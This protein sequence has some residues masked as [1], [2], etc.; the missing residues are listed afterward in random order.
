MRKS[1][2]DALRLIEKHRPDLAPEFLNLRHFGTPQVARWLD[3]HFPIPGGWG[4]RL[5]WRLALDLRELLE[6]AE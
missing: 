1:F 2:T 6:P 5:C 3:E 4:I